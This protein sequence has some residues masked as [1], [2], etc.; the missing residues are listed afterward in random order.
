MADRGKRR[1]GR[2]EIEEFDEEVVPAA[3]EE[4]PQPPVL[5][6][7]SLPAEE[8]RFFVDPQWYEEH[9]ISFSTVAQARLCGSCSMKLGTFIEERFPVV[10]PK[11]KRV[12]FEN[13]RV[14]YAANPLPIIRD[15]CSKSRDYITHETPLL[16]AIFRVFLANGNQPMTVATLREHLLTYLPEVAALRSEYPTQLLERM[17]RGDRAYGLREHKLPVAV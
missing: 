6:E 5:E 1:G 16:E 13:R 11:T 17:I 3:V 15:C 4:A 12:V 2:P 9:G 14:P 7:P 8:A 10:D